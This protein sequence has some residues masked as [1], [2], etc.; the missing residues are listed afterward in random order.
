MDFLS[1]KAHAPITS[2]LSLR[3]HRL[4]EVYLQEAGRGGS[5][6]SP[7]FCQSSSYCPLFLH[8]GPSRK[9]LFD[10]SVLWAPLSQKQFRNTKLEDLSVFFLSFNKTLVRILPFEMLF[11]CLLSSMKKLDC[12]HFLFFHSCHPPGT[13]LSLLP[14]RYKLGLIQCLSIGA[15]LNESW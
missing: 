9:I 14:V 2:Y 3:F 12:V 6:L 8:I 15:C 4:P 11:P 5:K 1:E 13:C 10:P 7:S